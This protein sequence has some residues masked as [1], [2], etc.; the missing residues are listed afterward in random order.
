[1]QLTNSKKW[2][3]QKM[4]SLLRKNAKGKIQKIPG[5]IKDAPELREPFSFY[6]NG[7]PVPFQ[8]GPVK[9]FKIQIIDENNEHYEIIQN[10]DNGALDQAKL[11][12]KNVQK[13]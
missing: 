13:R 1:M 11:G 6:L 7:R 3:T 2:K 12:V 4:A 9:H 8:T 10:S 5:Y